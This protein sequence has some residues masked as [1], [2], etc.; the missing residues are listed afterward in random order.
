RDLTHRQSGDGFTID[1]DFTFGWHELANHQTHQS[2]FSGTRFSLY[3]RQCARIDLKTHLFEPDVAV[4]K[5]FADGVEGNH[6]QIREVTRPRL[7]LL[8]YTRLG[9]RH[10]LRELRH[11]QRPSTN[12]P[13]DL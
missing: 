10:Q 5:N 13:S 3:K 2:G 8:T 1:K 12:Q 4:R 7:R 11:D 9:V 6:G